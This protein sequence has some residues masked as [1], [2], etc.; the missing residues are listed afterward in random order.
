MSD[1]RVVTHGNS[2]YA[3]GCRCAPCRDGHAD[4]MRAWRGRNGHSAKR[5]VAQNRAYRTAERR[6]REAHREE[7]ERLYRDERERAG[8]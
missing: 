7:F 6:L 5:D 8:L 3:A 2:G 4:Y 1:L